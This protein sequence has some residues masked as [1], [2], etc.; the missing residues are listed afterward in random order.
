[1]RRDRVDNDGG[2]VHSL[3]GPT[4][5]GKGSCATTQ[6]SEVRPVWKRALRMGLSQT[7]VKGFGLERTDAAVGHYCMWLKEQTSTV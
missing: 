6:E 5:K 3:I 2:V 4:P 1:M 7:S